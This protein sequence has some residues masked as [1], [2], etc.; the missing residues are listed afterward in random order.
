M[1]FGEGHRGPVSS[2][3]FTPDSKSLVTGG[4]DGTVRLWDTKRGTQLRLIGSHD[5][6]VY[7]VRVA[8]SGVAASGS[9]D[10]T[11]RL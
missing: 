3:A 11:A 4:W 2:A 8:P 7:S 6:H 5:G 10:E 9:A 1:A